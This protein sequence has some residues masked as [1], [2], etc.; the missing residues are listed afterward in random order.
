MPQRHWP[1]SRRSRRWSN[2]YRPAITLAAAF[3]AADQL[4]LDLVGASAA[5]VRLAGQELHFGRTPPVDAMQK[6]LD[7]LGRPSPLEV[8]SLDDVTLRHPEAAGAAGGRKR[9]PAAPPDIR[10]RRS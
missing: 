9:H 2:G 3:V 6:A 1:G 7:I 4:I 10:G 8:L 5:V